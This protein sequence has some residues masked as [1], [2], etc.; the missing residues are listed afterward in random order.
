MRNII[1]LIQRFYLFLLFLILQV[2]A[3][4]ILFNN[5]NFHRTEFIQHSNGLTGF[6]YSKRSSLSEYLRLSEINDE[7]SLENAVLRSERPENFLYLRTDQDTI[8]NATTLQR[9]VYRTAKVVN[10]TINREKNFITLDRGKLSGVDAD[11]GVIANGNLIGVVRSASDHY[12]VVMPIIH[13]DFRASVKLKRSGV[14]GS[15][16]WRGGDPSTADVVEIPKNIPVSVGDSII[17][18]GYSTYYPA[19]ILV[20][21]VD[22]IDDETSNEYHILK[23]KLAADIRMTSQVQVVG[24]LFKLEQDSLLNLVI[25]QDAANSRK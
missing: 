24:D 21:T 20:G 23:V 3:L 7:L 10:A 25:Q 13:A 9:Y 18:S 22:I 4:Y 6:V 16:Q 2:V 14:I 17:T 19:N 12:A 5:N 11:M 15:L 8:I 1:V